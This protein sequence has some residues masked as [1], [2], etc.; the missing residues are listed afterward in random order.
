MRNAIRLVASS[1]SLATT[2]PRSVVSLVSPSERKSG[3]LYELW[4]FADGLGYSI[5][6]S[7]ATVIGGA[8]IGLCFGPKLA[9]VGIGKHLVRELAID[10]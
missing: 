9:A 1:L 7:T 2:Q 10:S 8:I 5:V 4:N 6:Q 3:S